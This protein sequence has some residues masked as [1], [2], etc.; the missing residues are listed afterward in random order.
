MGESLFW[1]GPFM[2]FEVIV[3]GGGYTGMIAAAAL[4]RTG[5]VSLCSPCP[6]IIREAAMHARASLPPA[7]PKAGKGA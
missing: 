4:S 1:R 2:S 7:L 3:V 6:S 5:L